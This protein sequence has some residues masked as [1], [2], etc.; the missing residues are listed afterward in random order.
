MFYPKLFGIIFVWYVFTL[1]WKGGIVCE[2]AKIGLRQSDVYS[3]YYMGLAEWENE[4][5]VSYEM[6]CIDLDLDLDF[7]Y[8]RFKTNKI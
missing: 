8:F 4:L 7:I 2:S 5:N 3:M 1:G 6:H